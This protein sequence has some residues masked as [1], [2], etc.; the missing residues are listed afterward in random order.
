LFGQRINAI[1]LAGFLLRDHLFVIG[2]GPPPTVEDLKRELFLLLGFEE[3]GFSRAL[4]DENEAFDVGTVWA[5][6]SP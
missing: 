1:A 2:N 3:G 5:P 4:F 6:V